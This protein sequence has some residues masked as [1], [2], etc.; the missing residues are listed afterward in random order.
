MACIIIVMMFALALGSSTHFIHHAPASYLH[1]QPSVHAVHNRLVVSKVLYQHILYVCSYYDLSSVFQQRFVGYDA[2]V[3]TWTFA[4]Y[5]VASFTPLQLEATVTYE[6]LYITTSATATD[7]SIHLVNA[8]P[9]AKVDKLNGNKN[10]LH[11]WVKETY[12][13]GTAGEEYYLYLLIDN[14]AAGNYKVGP[15]TVYVDTKGNDQIR[16]CDVILK[17]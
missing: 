2:G 11:I 6:Q 1:S 8:D 3:A 4:P 12:S 5:K 14:N 7:V 13:D 9:S 15:Y 16:A 10:G 17:P